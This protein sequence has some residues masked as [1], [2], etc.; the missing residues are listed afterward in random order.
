MHKF[1]APVINSFTS[2]R[3]GGGSDYTLIDADG[4][5]RFFGDAT[6]WDDLR[7]AASS[8]KLGGSKD[9]DYA[10]FLTNG[11]GSQGVFA[12]RFDK[13]AEE[14]VYFDIQLPHHRKAS[15]S[16]YPHVHW[17]PTTTQENTFVSW[18]L[19]YSWADINEEFTNTDII[20]GN[21]PVGGITTLT[22]NHHLLTPLPIID[23]TGHDTGVGVSSMLKCR[24][25]RDA[26]G[27]GATDDYNYDAILLEFDLHIEIDSVGSRELYT[28]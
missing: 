26:A 6:V 27:T 5:I 3:F 22:A 16:L 18:G 2:G 14:E 28:K 7:V 12:L 15:S 21:V 13:A 9:P 19:E 24:L 17:A 20:Y 8:T 25:F 11:S 23:G 4:S 1:N 10:V